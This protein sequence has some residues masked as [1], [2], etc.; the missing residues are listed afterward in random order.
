MQLRLATALRASVG[1]LLHQGIQRLKAWSK[2]NSQNFVGG[3]A[4][5][6]VRSRKELVLENALLR[7]QVI[8][9]QRQVKRPRLT[10]RERGIMV[11]LAS[12]PRQWQSALL[13]VQPDTLLRWHRDLFRWVWRRKS[14]PRRS[15]GKPRL[16]PDVVELI[17]RIARE[18]RLWGAER[19]RGEL[20]KLNLSVAKSSIQKYTHAPRAFSPPRQSWR[21]FL[22]NHASDIWACDF[23]QTYDLYFR[24]LFIF[25]IIEL[26]SRRVIHANVTRQPTD[27]WVAQQLRDAT[28]FGTAPRFLLRDNDRKYGSEFQQVAAGAGIDILRT[29]VRAPRANAICERFLGS[30]R[31][32][33]LDYILIVTEQ[34][35][36]QRLREYIRY[37][38]YARPHQGLDQ[39]IPQSPHELVV[40]VGTLVVTSRPILG[41]L[42]HDYQRPAA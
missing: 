33:C 19:I 40:P 6:T 2:P 20:L 14:Q 12:Q 15:G 37:F 13:I 34:Q 23:L 11:A 16:S 18:N 39:R 32:E 27:Q 22:H 42:H 29:P 10:W 41:G 30:L 31:R 17:R 7:Q 8:V 24:S 5:D 38:N 25:V 28:P 26:G 36:R 1:H 21:T 35:L 3:I 4:F 9:L